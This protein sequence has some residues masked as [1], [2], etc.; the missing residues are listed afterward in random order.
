MALPPL[1]A[2]RAFDAVARH[3]SFTRAADELGMTQA[4]VSYQIRIL[5]ERLGTALF[6]RKARH[7]LL[8]DA[9]AKL[10]PQVRQAFEIM[11]EAFANTRGTVEGLLSITTVPT[12]TSKCET[13]PTPCAS[14]RVRI[15]RSNSPLC[16]ST[17]VLV[18]STRTAISGCAI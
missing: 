16:R 17:I 13:I 6:L 9:G 12:F 4:A 1:N 15:A 11:R 2:V 10:A 14:G 5:E 7:I 3:L 8:T 18:L